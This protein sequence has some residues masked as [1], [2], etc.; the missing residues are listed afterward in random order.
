LEAGYI[1]IGQ[2]WR[3]ATFGFFHF[4]IIHLLSNILILIAL[5]IGYEQVLGPWNFLAIYLISGLVGGT[6]SMMAVPAGNILGASAAVFGILG[7]SIVWQ[8]QSVL[9]GGIITL[10][11]I[12]LI[13]AQG[14]GVLAHIV[15]VIT[16]IA[17]DQTQLR[18][19]K[20]RNARAK[21]KEAALNQV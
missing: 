8:V 11:I 13:P 6:I 7:A 10:L 4:N 9:F 17:V 5:G 15:G 1:A 20:F 21:Q 16:G 18:I 12:A 14:I 19:N 2:Y 3:L